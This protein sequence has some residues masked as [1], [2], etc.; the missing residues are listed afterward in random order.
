MRTVL[1][2]VICSSI[3][4]TVS[5]AW[6]VETVDDSGFVGLD[7]A[8]ALDS[9]GQPRIAYPRDCY[10]AKYAWYNGVDWEI[11]Y[12]HEEYLVSSG[13]YDIVVDS[14]DISHVVF[15]GSHMS[16]PAYAVRDS[17]ASGWTL[18][19]LPVNA[20][21]M[22]LDLNSQEQPCIAILDSDEDN[23]FLF[24]HGTGWQV[25]FIEEGNDYWGSISL[26]MDGIDRA[27]VGPPERSSSLSLQFRG[28]G[29]EREIRFERHSGAVDHFHR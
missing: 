22:S 14:G 10:G 8:I 3:L 19:Y 28:N 17:A 11:E 7:P 25:E 4:T 21:W 20:T 6:R 26:A 5:A 23:R 29:P 16:G 12:I 9:E 27:Q 1:Y 24:N 2:I 15:S 13:W 18:D